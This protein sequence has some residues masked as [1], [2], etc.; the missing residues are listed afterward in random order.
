MSKKK[1]VFDRLLADVDRRE[2][3]EDGLHEEDEGFQSMVSVSSNEGREGTRK[4]EVRSASARRKT[5]KRSRRLLRTIETRP[6]EKEKH[7]PKRIPIRTRT[8][9]GS[10][11]HLPTH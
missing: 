8:P 10:F 7:S 2:Q 1:D 5:K 11:H 6:D 9:L 3:Q 4:G